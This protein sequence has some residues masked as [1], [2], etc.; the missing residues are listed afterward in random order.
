MKVCVC[1]CVSC[2]TYLRKVFIVDMREQL[3]TS[4]R[5]QRAERERSGLNIDSRLDMARAI[6]GQQQGVET[7]ENTEREAGAELRELTKEGRVT[8]RVSSS[9][10]EAQGS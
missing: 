5:V 7:R 9:G 10:K 4:G 8:R 6:E 1:V 3:D 2:R